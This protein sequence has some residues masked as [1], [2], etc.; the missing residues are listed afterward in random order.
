MDFDDLAWCPVSIGA[1]WEEECQPEPIV[2]TD[3][4]RFDHAW[5]SAPDYI[6]PSGVGSLHAGRYENFGAWLAERIGRVAVWMPH[7]CLHRGEIVF[8]DGRHRF[9]WLRDHGLA[10]LPMT[11]SGE[12]EKEFRERFE[13]AIR[14]GRGVTSTSCS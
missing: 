7:V 12:A 6:G 14:V 8:S 2:W 9:A 10:A 11:V 13:T 5:R 3:V 4:A 1:G